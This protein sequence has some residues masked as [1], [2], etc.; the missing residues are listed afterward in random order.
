VRVGRNVGWW[1]IRQLDVGLVEKLDLSP[2]PVE[3]A[4][5]IYDAMKRMVTGSDLEDIANNYLFETSMRQDYGTMEQ[6]V[7]AFRQAVKQANR[8]SG[9]LIP[10]LAVALLLL[11]GI[12]RLFFLQA[13]AVG[14]GHILFHML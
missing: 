10:P 2:T 1:I 4:D 5:E 11:R 14:C 8:S 3:F 7:N 9:T 6:F 13:M 12:R